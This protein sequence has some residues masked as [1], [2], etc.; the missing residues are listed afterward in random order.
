MKFKASWLRYYTVDVWKEGP[1]RDKIANW[2]QLSHENKISA[3][4]NPHADDVAEAAE[5]PPVRLKKA[6]HHNVHAGE[7]IEDIKGWRRLTEC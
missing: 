1:A 7:V 6:I 5:A 3:S 2:Q 4:N